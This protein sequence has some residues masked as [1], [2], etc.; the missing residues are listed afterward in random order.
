M[1][2]ED[3]EGE[4]SQRAGVRHAAASADRN[5]TGEEQAFNKASTNRGYHHEFGHGFMLRGDED[6]TLDR[7]LLNG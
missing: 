1:N 5:R 6:R 3:E 4:G 7:A 2:S